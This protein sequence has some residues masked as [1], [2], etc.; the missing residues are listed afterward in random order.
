MK[1]DL[2]NGGNTQTSNVNNEN[3]NTLEEKNKEEN[4]IEEDSD[5]I[6]K[7]LDSQL[8]EEVNELKKV[9]YSLDDVYYTK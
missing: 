1:N 9:Q 3:V 4:K 6:Q 8:P 2:G 7:E 5:L